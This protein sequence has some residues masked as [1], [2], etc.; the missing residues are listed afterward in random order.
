MTLLGKRFWKG[1]CWTSQRWRPLLPVIVV[2]IWLAVAGMASADEPER[3]GDAW[4][5]ERN[6]IVQ[7]FGGERLGLWSLK[8]VMRTEPPEVNT[9]DRAANP[10]DR[11]IL[12]RLEAV[13]KT[14]SPRADQRQLA[15]RLYFDLTGLPPTPEQLARFLADG[16]P[17]AYERLVDELLASP[18]YGEHAARQ[19]LDVVRYGDSNGFD[20]DEFRPQAWRFR[21]YAIRSFNA[22]KPLDQFIREHL[23]GDELLAGPPCTIEEQEMLIA[24]TYLRLGPQD[25]SAGLFNEQPR[26]RAELLADLVETTGSAFLALTLACCRCHDHKHDPISQA[27]HFRLRAFFEAVKYADDTPL[28]LA[29]EQE[30]IARHNADIDQQVAQAEA[31]R[32]AI[33]DAVKQGLKKG[34]AEPSDNEVK[35]AYNDDE[36][37]SDDNL[38]KSIERLRSQRKKYEVGLLMTDEPGDIPT[39][40]ILYQG[41]HKQPREAVEP[42]FLSI[43][44]PAPSTIA[45]SA[46]DRTKGR[47]LTLANWIASPENPLTARVFVNRVWQQHFGR[48]LVATP[49]DFGYSGARPT[50]PELLDYL[51]SEFV[52]EGW[53]V[54]KLH[55]L[56]VTSETYCQSSQVQSLA[57][58]DDENRLYE[59]QNL[60]RLS[61]E[62]LR[63]ALLAVSGLLA[64]KTGGK[65]VWPELPPEILQANPA[66]LD[67][68]A[69]RTKGWYP[70]PAAEQ[71][72]RSVYLVQK[73]TVRVPFMETF[74]LP[75]NSTSCGRR[76]RSTVAPQAFALLN[77]PLAVE[78]AEA[79]ADTVRRE[80]KD[81][82]RQ[83]DRCFELALQ[84]SPDADEVALCRELLDDRGLV[85]LCR[86]LLN[87]NEFAYVD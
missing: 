18:S 19:W 82:E 33:Q 46:S 87:L 16:S 2:A 62:Q 51:A 71:A 21:D 39:T 6:P 79:F 20:W 75:E 12:A 15:R 40:H 70:S 42:G 43:F 58:R 29:E 76:D 67:D 26:A 13:E 47:R 38:A 56:I 5:D 23:A 72:V 36:R 78:A 73:R 1:H 3:I 64:P 25:N 53:S 85:E 77:S 28:N 59:R 10:I 52:R 55:R 24:T 30:E 22:D 7:I 31:N 61:A 14:L 41:D 35:A 65:P 63:D 9:F 37:K 83:V 81:A 68:N 86:V 60:R 80:A 66:F 44:D 50:H 11:F 84:R 74:D 69:T 49:N 54:K 4:H 32:A 34:E 8:P 48:G 27:D 45:Q 17:D 57:E